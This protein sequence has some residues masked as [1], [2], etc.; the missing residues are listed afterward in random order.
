MAQAQAELKAQRARYEDERNELTGDEEEVAKA[1][2]CA[3]ID[4]I[5]LYASSVEDWDEDE[6]QIERGAIVDENREIIYLPT[7]S[8][9]NADVK[10]LEVNLRKVS[11][12]LPARITVDAIPGKVFPGRVSQIAPLPDS[13]DWFS[14]PNLKVYNTV[15]AVDAND[16][17]LRNGMS[18]RVEILVQR[19]P[20]AVY[21]PIQ[22]VTRVNRQPTVHV[23]VDGRLVPQP[24]EIGLD[25]NRFVHVLSG[26]EAGEVISL[27]PPLASSE[28]DPEASEPNAVSEPNRGGESPS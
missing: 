20:D 15:I 7:A 1:I 24:V 28:A 10:I 21:V 17:A 22:A 12:G 25:N 26:L 5:A 11:V 6:P 8:T 14:N 13:D 3:P 18:C 4:G 2:I 19:Y 16:P 27:A 9:F 23:L